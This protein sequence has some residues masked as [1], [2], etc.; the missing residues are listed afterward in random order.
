MKVQV[1]DALAGG[2]SAVGKKSV[3]ICYAKLFSKLLGDLGDFGNQREIFFLQSLETGYLFFGH[4]QDVHRRGWR[5]IFNGEDALIFKHLLAG[6]FSLDNFAEYGGHN[7]FNA[8]SKAFRASSS[9]CQI[10]MNRPL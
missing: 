8:S 1:K 4:D 10:E 5:D 6:E 9:V 3:A 7:F 2:S